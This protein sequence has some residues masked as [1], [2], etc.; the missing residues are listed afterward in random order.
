MGESSALY[1]H[2][3]GPAVLFQ[4]IRSRNSIEVKRLIEDQ[5]VAV[6]SEGPLDETDDVGLI[7][8]FFRQCSRCYMRRSTF[9]RFI[10]LAGLSM[11]RSPQFCSIWELISNPTTRH[12]IL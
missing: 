4:A 1:G 12:V 3:S 10:W 2:L 6:S 9:L 11:K 7:H 8:A 5:G